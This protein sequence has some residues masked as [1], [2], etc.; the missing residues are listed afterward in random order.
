MAQRGAL[1]HYGNIILSRGPP[2]LRWVSKRYPLQRRPIKGGPLINSRNS[3]VNPVVIYKFNFF[4]VS[5]NLELLSYFLL[6]PVVIWIDSS[7]NILCSINFFQSKMFGLSDTM[8]TRLSGTMGKR[9]GFMLMGAIFLAALFFFFSLF[10]LFSN[11]T[12]LSCARKSVPV[13]PRCA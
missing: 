10:F 7:Q 3:S 11:L 9:L 2:L 5:H 12:F 8:G 6:Y 4:M 1:L 13:R